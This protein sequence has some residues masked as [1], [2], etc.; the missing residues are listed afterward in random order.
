MSWM[1]AGYEYGQ[2]M[3]AWV[4]PSLIEANYIL[5]LSQQ[6]LE[7]VIAQEMAGNPA[8]EIEER[9]SCPTCGGVL[10][11]T[12]CSTCMMDVRVR[13]EESTRDSWEDFPEQAITAVAS[14]PDDSDFDPMTLV[15]SSESI[16]EQILSDVRTVLDE[17]DAA[18][19]EYLL[20]SLDDR[21]FLAQSLDE[22]AE[23]TGID[24]EH[25]HAVLD[26]IRD[27]APVGVGAHDL[28]ECLLLQASYLIAIGYDVPPATIPI[29]D[30]AMTEF[31]AH[32]YGQIARELDVSIE[33]IEA[34]R[35]FIR[36]QLNP[37]PLQS[38][39]GRSWRSPSDAAFVAPD[40]VIDLKDGELTVDVVDSKYF[41]L[42]T[43]TLYDQ[44]AGQFAKR[45]SLPQKNA[46]VSDDVR[47]AASTVTSEDKDH[48]RLYT[49]RA[50]MFISN[51]Q[52]RRDTLLRISQCI[53][54]LQESFLRDGVREL[55]PLTRAVVA[56]QVGVH[57]STVSRATASKYVML[58][59]RKVIPF[60]DFFTPSLS[61]KD[62]IKELIV[63]ES[64]KGTSL[65][66]RKICD[67]LLQRGVR[68]ARRTVAKYR[69]ELGILPSTMR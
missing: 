60:S 8:L 31:G 10:D 40:V 32:K 2:E 18:I 3:R 51:I 48:I 22:I 46:V 26:V 6:E 7:Q 68:I 56:Q 30:N 65:T 15:A 42:R 4:S 20:E 11:G 61:T 28:R 9:A 16:L 47:D 21:G 57:E 50:R 34:A 27:V 38:G 14:G 24:E 43:N 67:L 41:H 55:R 36:E 35:D 13:P 23:T 62:I 54:E 25:L 33:D 53:C 59:N 63:E 64:R 17:R 1:E 12:W 19:A 39:Q 5:S 52:Q 58:P 37:F 29:I 69:A 45:K 44:L 66:D 49:N